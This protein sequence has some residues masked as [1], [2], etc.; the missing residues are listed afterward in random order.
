MA[1]AGA[2]IGETLS[3]RTSFFLDATPL[4]EVNWTGI[5]VVCANIARQLMRR[6]LRLEFCL[7][8]SMIPR[9][10][11]LKALDRS[12]GLYLAHDLETERLQKTALTWSRD[13]VTVGLSSSVKRFNRVFDVECSWIHDISTLL[14]PEYHTANNIAWHMERIIEDLASNELTVCISQATLDDVLVYLGADANR[15]ILAHNGV[16]WP[17]W[18]PLRVKN[19]HAEAPYLLVLGTR[20][21]RKNLSLVFATLAAFPEVLA[22]HRVIVVGQDGWFED[23]MA[24]PPGLSSAIADGRIAAT[25]FVSD[26]DKYRLLKGADATLFPSLFEGFGLPVLESLSVGT[27]CVA[28]FSSSIPEVGGALC[29]YFDPFSV[30]SLHDALRDTLSRDLKRDASF[31]AAAADWTRR[32]TWEASMDAVL[33][34]LAPLVEEARARK[35]QSGTVPFGPAS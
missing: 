8:T 3:R 22:S 12:S 13:D 25:G 15:V 5:S 34:A 26:Y 23:Q 11:V 2:P 17:W 24:A 35:P 10:A 4:L 14:Q 20:E 32:F 19:E 1:D 21:P 31:A 30:T 16:E 28:S 9:G 18:Y 7:G 6:G 27:P 29:R 33:T